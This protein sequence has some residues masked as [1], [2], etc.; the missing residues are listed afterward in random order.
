MR[1]LKLFTAVAKTSLCIVR[2]REVML[3]NE[4]RVINTEMVSV[5]MEKGTRIVA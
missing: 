2:L 4:W 5:A 1:Y 3:R